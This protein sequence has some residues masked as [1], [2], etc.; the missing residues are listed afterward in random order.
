[1]SPRLL[2]LLTLPCPPLWSADYLDRW[3]AMDAV[4]SPEKLYAGR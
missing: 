4:R 3:R 1:M 2:R